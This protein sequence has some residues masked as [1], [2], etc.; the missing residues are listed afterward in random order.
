[1][2][3]AAKTPNEADALPASQRIV[4]LRTTVTVDLPDGRS[5]SQMSEAN[6]L[7]MT[8]T[9]DGWIR[10]ELA[11]DFDMTKV[12][13]SAPSAVEVPPHHVAQIYYG[14]DDAP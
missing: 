6:G 4:R 10:I 7:R 11:P 8:K 13:N 12:P 1:M 14:R 2:K 3:C 9:V 5:G